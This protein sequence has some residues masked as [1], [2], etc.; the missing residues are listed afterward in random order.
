MNTVF[1][2]VVFLVLA[3]A[4]GRR[5]HESGNHGQHLFTKI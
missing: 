5:L 1:V 3:F 4:M 2:P